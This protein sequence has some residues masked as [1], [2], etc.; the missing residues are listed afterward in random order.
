MWGDDYESRDGDKYPAC[1][2]V[3]IFYTVALS[4]SLSLG[5]RQVIE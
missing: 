1:A 5:R 3:G 4:L 2:F